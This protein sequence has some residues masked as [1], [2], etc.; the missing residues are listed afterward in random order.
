MAKLHLLKWHTVPLI[1]KLHVGLGL[2]AEQG[3][4]CLKFEHLDYDFQEHSQQHRAAENCCRPAPADDYRSQYP[5]AWLT[6]RS[7]K[8]QDPSNFLR[9]VAV[10]HSFRKAI[11]FSDVHIVLS[12]LSS[13]FRFLNYTAIHLGRL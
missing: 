8:R 12:T 11:I 6:R 3:A 2:L 5:V 4:E 9:Q 10:R 7:T 13:N 1:R